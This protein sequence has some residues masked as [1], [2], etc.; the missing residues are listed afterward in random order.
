MSPS[1]NLAKRNCAD[2]DAEY[3]GRDRPFAVGGHWS[4]W[5][6]MYL[7]DTGK[8][9]RAVE[10]IQEG[11]ATVRRHLKVG[12]TEHSQIRPE[13]RKLVRYLSELNEQLK[14]AGFDVAASS[15]YHAWTNL[16]EFIKKPNAGGG[17]LR[18]LQKAA[19]H[20]SNVPDRL[21][22]EAQRFQFA[23]LSAQSS[24]LMTGGA[25]FGESVE[26]RFPEAI[27]DIEEA[28]KCLAFGRPTATVF[29]LM[30]AMESAVAVLNTDLQA[31]IEDTNGQ[32]LAW[33]KL[34]ANMGRAIEKFAPGELKDR[35]SAAHAL[36]YA[37][38]RGFRTPT[39]HP[40]K[41]YT[42]EEAQT[43][44]GATKA[45]MQA[46]AELAVIQPMPAAEINNPSA[47]KQGKAPTKQ[48]VKDDDR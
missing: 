37:V 17:E 14:P 28:A 5:D 15:I 32:R 11:H 30:R 40:V 47:P 3:P 31:T 8:V 25:L 13:I 9:T 35:W 6:I 4:L 46:I 24:S 1:A 19:N 7:F 36:L 21:R 45:F 42:L 18:N 16:R 27:G 20:L 12:D 44:Y 26:L 48:R 38:N 33:G 34:V 22:D 10:H 39:A 2:D 43:A 41:S 29:H 23:S